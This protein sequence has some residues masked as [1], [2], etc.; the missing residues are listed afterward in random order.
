MKTFDPA[1]ISTYLISQKVNY[2][3]LELDFSMNEL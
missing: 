2:S 3:N 1:R